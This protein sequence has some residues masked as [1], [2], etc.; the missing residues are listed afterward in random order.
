MHATRKKRIVRIVA[1]LNIGGPA[2]H[3]VWL[4]GLSGHGYE[5]TLVCGTTPS[6]EGDM[7]WFADQHGVTPVVIREMSREICSKDIIVIWRL[8]NLLRQY[9]PDIVHTHTAKAGT[10]GRIAAW[11]YKYATP[12]TLWGRPNACRILHTFHGH[13]FHSYYSRAKTWIFLTIERLLARFATD[14]IVV[15]SPQQL[16]E[17]HNRFGV[18]VGEDQ[19]SVVPLGLDLDGLATA[20]RVDAGLR[21]ELG[22]TK[23]QLLVGI[24]GRVTE[25]KNIEMFIDGVRRYRDQ[26]ATPDRCHFAVIGDGNLTASLK[27]S[28]RESGLNNIISFVGNRND[29]EVFYPDIDILALTSLNEGTPLSVIEAM[30]CRKAVLATDVGSVSHLLG[31]AV[32]DTKN[33]VCQR[34]RGLTVPSRDA[35]AFATGLCELE[36]NRELRNRLGENASEF[37]LEHY[38]KDRLLRDISNVYDELTVGTT[39]HREVQVTE[40]S[41]E[42]NKACVY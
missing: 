34:E 28:V 8:F 33:N 40:Q 13:I 38:S 7:S 10:V 24:V 36:S 25:V 19:F 29:R 11:L 41:D 9:R 20:T 2:Q 16:D 32:A 22:V 1:R 5:T 15:I 12:S 3:V 35:E 26:S 37:V 31:S 14:R 27:Q 6:T 18:G 21:R 17:I 23:D 4:D 30:A 42:E 39:S